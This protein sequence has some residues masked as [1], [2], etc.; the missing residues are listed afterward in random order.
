MA[1]A[2]LPLI[3][4]FCE[5]A[6]HELFV[7]AMVRRLEREL[8]LRVSLRTQVAR[9]GHGRVLTELRAWQALVRK[10]P[11]LSR[12]RPDL[13]LIVID[14][15]CK[16]W[17]PMRAEVERVLDKSQVSSVLI[18]CPDPHIEKWCFADPGAMK[19]VVGLVPPSVPDKCE[20]DLYKKLLRDTLAE[21]GAVSL[22]SEM[23]VAPDLVKEMDLFQAG[24]AE[25]SLKHLIEGLRSAF[26]LLAAR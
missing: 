1:E 7:R 6:G 26:K 22:T 14:C 24:K 25:P 16:G 17:N 8:R 20:R 21:A 2:G 19:R 9:G 11:S 15:N 18:A 10:S 3:D 23:E 13:V 5:D 12:E 4:L